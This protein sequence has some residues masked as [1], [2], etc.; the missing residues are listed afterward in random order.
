MGS[1]LLARTH[2]VLMDLVGHEALHLDL[3]SHPK[4]IGLIYERAVVFQ[5][6]LLAM[7]DGANS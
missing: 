7:S 5:Q 3:G 6:L 1:Q 4:N 2:R